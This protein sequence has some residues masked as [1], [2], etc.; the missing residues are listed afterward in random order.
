MLWRRNKSLTAAGNE[1]T[2]S[3]TFNLWPK[4]YTVCV[5]VCVCVCKYRVH[6]T[7]LKE[8]VLRDVV[9]AAEESI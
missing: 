6:C 1:A 2:I 4:H 9:Y 5:C 3:R 8:S 7:T